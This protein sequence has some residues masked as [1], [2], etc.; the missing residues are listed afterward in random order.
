VLLSCKSITNFTYNCPTDTLIPQYYP[1]LLEILH[2]FVDTVEALIFRDQHWWSRNISPIRHLTPFLN[3]KHFTADSTIVCRDVR[4]HPLS[5]IFP[6][7]IGNNR[8]LDVFPSLIS[9]LGA[10]KLLNDLQAKRFPCLRKITI[11]RG[12]VLYDDEINTHIGNLC[13]NGI[14]LEIL[15]MASIENGIEK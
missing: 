8:L 2:S 4:K 11:V 13:R 12:L 9:Q 7:S 3:L 1:E 10:S 6:S 5:W 14:I 15:N